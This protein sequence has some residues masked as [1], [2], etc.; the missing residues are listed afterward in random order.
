MKTSGAITA[1][2]VTY[3]NTHGTNG[4]V[5]ST[6]GS[7]ALTW[8]TTSG[9]VDLTTAQTVAGAK[10][11]SSDLNV[12][13]INFGR[14][15]SNNIDNTAIGYS[16]LNSNT[17]FYNT[18]IGTSALQ[19]N[20]TG[21]WNTATGRGALA[22]NT[23]GELNTANGASALYQ[24]TT[25][26]SNTAIGMDALN[27]NTTGSYNTANGRA[28]LYL[29]T[30]GDYNTASGGYALY[31]NTSGYQNTAS[32]FNSLISNTSG[33]QNTASGFNSLNNNTTGNYNTASGYGA[34]SSITTGSNNIAIGYNAQVAVAANSNQIR[35]GDENITLATTKVAWTTSS[36]KR[37]KSN[38]QNSNLGLDF[39]TK[40]HPV[41]YYRNNDE[42]KKTEYGFIA[43]E[44]EATLNNAGATNNGIISKD[45]K[46]MYSVRYNDLLAPMVKAIQ[47]QQIIIE[48]QQKQIDDLKFLVNKLIDKK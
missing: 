16:T 39:I 36:D 43:Q 22:Y 25:G 9:F 40:L 42:S 1:D 13:G 2:V 31:S 6:T 35:I 3:P 20:T 4:Q 5:L 23:S 47:E 14:G 33:Y 34:G 18:A 45:D 11:F 12:N 48:K 38:I 8:T 26:N 28:S 24:N 46:G 19:R 21:S 37:W 17:G 30:T 32:G 29:N 44:L 10:T 7:G 41:S 27:F 15:G